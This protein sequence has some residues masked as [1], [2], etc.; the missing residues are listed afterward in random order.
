[1]RFSVVVGLALTMLGGQA[2]YAEQSDPHIAD[3]KVKRDSPDLAGIYHI[4]VTIEHEDTG[5]D[6]YVDAWE[7]IGSDGSVLGI[8]PFFEPELERT[9]T[10]T[11]L[12]GVVIPEDVKKVTIRARK[13]PQGYQ[14]EAVEITIPH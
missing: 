4:K 5:W 8:R 2:G 11:A 6:D 12:A 3:V 10:V 7:I 1:M 9:K 14:G 13:H